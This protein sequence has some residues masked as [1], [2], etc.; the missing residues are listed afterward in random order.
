MRKFLII[1]FCLFWFFPFNA[2]A[3][4]KEMMPKEN[5]WALQ[6]MINENFRLSSFQGATISLLKHI[7]LKK[8]WRFGFDGGVDYNKL[9]KIRPYYDREGSKEYFVQYDLHF[10][11]DLQLLK[12]VNTESNINLFYG[13]GPVVSYR[14]IKGRTKAHD[15]ITG[16]RVNWECGAKFVFGTQLFLARSISIH[17][18]YSTSFVYNFQWDRT[19]L[20]QF[21][22]ANQGRLVI[23]DI[24]SEGFNLS[25][26]AVKFGLSAYF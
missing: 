23:D 11:I 5:A 8:A 19:E 3:D 7:S 15:P 13:W 20:W 6:F 25:S 9:N 17:A 12:Y 26:S 18:E 4:M 10:T 16:L 2:M 1:I 14:Y 24:Q 22:N 21:N